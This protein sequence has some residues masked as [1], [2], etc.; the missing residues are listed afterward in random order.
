MS[1][2][3]KNRFEYEGKTW[4]AEPLPY[5]RLPD[6]TL[7]KVIKTDEHGNA[8]VTVSTKKS[9]AADE[10]AAATEFKVSPP[11]ERPAEEDP[12]VAFKA[13]WSDARAAA[14][15]AADA[16]AAA[17][18]AIAA[19]L[20]KRPKKRGEVV[21]VDLGGAKYRAQKSKDGAQPSLVPLPK[22]GATL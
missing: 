5:V 17:E 13:K 16:Q 3:V 9:P 22:V 1:D 15:A 6:Q 11:E 8:Q 7:L 14:V 4:E 18:A 19:E 20:L 10:V 12:L 21:A 2:K